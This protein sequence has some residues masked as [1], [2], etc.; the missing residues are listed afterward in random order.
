MELGQSA[1]TLSGGE[2]QRLKLASE[3]A[4]PS[5]GKTIY[6]LD[7]PTT[8]LHFADTA[9]LLDV[10]NRL[11]DQGNTVVMIEHNTTVVRAAD[12]I[13]DLGPEGG[14]SGGHVVVAGTPEEI[15]ACPD[16]HTGAVLRATRA[17]S[18]PVPA[19]KNPP[20]LLAEPLPDV[21]GL[22]GVQVDSTV[23]PPWKVDGV[24]WHTDDSRLREGRRPLWKGSM[25]TWVIEEL[26]KIAPVSVVWSNQYLVSIYPEGAHRWVAMRTDSWQFV[27]IE[28][29]VPKGSLQGD[30]LRKQLNLRPFDELDDVPLYGSWSRV[31][32][33]GRIKT[34]TMVDIVTMRQEELDTEGF[35]AFLRDAYEKFIHHDRTAKGSKT[36]V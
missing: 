15:A 17:S 26:K 1:T 21:D 8:G 28:V 7:E 23:T 20:I 6:I 2:A 22:L 34:W 27:R 24:S 33:N 36:N 31:T 35:R 12:W 9:K 4:R 10:L 14:E 25:I 30:E 16:S 13:I 5:T 18:H 19:T 3:L 29:R 32:M 11:V